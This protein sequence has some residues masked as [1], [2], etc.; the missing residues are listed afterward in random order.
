MNKIEWAK[1]LLAFSVSRLV[2]AVAMAWLI[3]GGIR[4]ALAAE[5]KW[6]A[7]WDRTVRAA[8]QEGQ[9]SVSIGGYGA[10]IEFGAFQKAYP[11]IKV[12]HITGAGTDI[13]QRI[14][15]ERRAGKYLLDVYNGGGVSLHQTLYFGKMLEPIKP[16]LILPD[17]LDPSKW[18]EG[19]H[20]Y[21]D[22]EGEYI[23]VYEG[24]V[25]AG[26]GA[27]YQ[28]AAARCARVQELLG[29]VQSKAQGQDPF[30]RYSPRARRGDSLAVP[31]LS[32]L[33]W[34]Q[35]ICAASSVKWT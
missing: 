30:Q 26:A 10:I 31:L 28:H 6:Q 11:K 2:L 4:S 13:T 9:V 33:R 5:S 34:G 16:A 3:V 21:S 12:N 19:K 15:A 27:A 22:K 8:E 25:A 17:V 24:N 29:F 1:I 7:E 14:I 20:K 35:S 18:W 23:F 32:V